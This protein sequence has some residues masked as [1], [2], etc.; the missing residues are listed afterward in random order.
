MMVFLFC[1]TFFGKECRERKR[2]DPL[3]PADPNA[4]QHLQALR[5]AGGA[6]SVNANAGGWG[7]GCVQSSILLDANND[8]ISFRGFDFST[9]FARSRHHECIEITWAD[10]LHAR[11]DSTESGRV[12]SVQTTHGLV[13]IS[14]VF[15]PFDTL[16]TVI[17]DAIEVNR[18]YPGKY[19]AAFA[20]APLIKTP[21][22]GWGIVAAAALGAIITVAI[23]V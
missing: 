21:W 14:D 17:M 22:W 1:T 8:R 13:R 10:L 20:R 19:R 16:T 12:L 3:R 7:H 15:Q 11:V 5:E 23:L 9:S 2:S 18:E 6:L 4:G